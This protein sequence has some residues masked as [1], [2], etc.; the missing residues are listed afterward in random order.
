MD[1]GWN[2]NKA[3][4]FV[5]LALDEIEKLGEK[6]SPA[7]AEAL[8]DEF[9]R[10]IHLAFLREDLGAVMDISAEYSRRFRILGEDEM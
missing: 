6:L 8:L 3:N 4:E 9:E 7:R 5:R 1:D 2:A 10:D